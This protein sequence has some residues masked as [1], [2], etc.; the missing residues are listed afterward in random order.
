MSAAPQ[1]NATL[2]GA[3]AAFKIESQVRKSAAHCTPTADDTLAILRQAQVLVAQV[4]ATVDRL[5]AGLGRW[6]SSSDMTRQQPTADAANAVTT[7]A[8]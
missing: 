2:V 6:A 4:A 3:S 1:K 7:R 5:Q 8:G